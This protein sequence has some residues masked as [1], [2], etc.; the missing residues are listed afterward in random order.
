MCI[1][2]REDGGPAIR[3]IDA[4]RGGELIAVFA[5]KAFA[6]K[7][8]SN[9]DLGSDTDMFHRDAG[10]LPSPGGE[11]HL[12][13]VTRD[14]EADVPGRTGDSVGPLLD[15]HRTPVSKPA[16]YTF[17]VRGREQGFVVSP[18]A[19]ANGLRV[20][21]EPSLHESEAEVLAVAR[22]SPSWMLA[23]GGGAVA[24]DPDYQSMKF[25]AGVALVIS[26]DSSPPFDPEGT[27]LFRIVPSGSSKEIDGTVQ[28]DFETAGPVRPARV[29]PRALTFVAPS[30]TDAEPQRMTLANT[31]SGIVRFRLGNTASWLSAEPRAGVL[32]PYQSAEIGIRTYSVGVVPDTY[33]RAVTVH[34]A[35]EMGTSIGDQVIE[36]AFA[37]VPSVGKSVR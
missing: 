11:G 24:P 37:V 18:P 8:V 5:V 7:A 4:S 2:D 19:G 35:D 12:P 32:Q 27:Y 16:S 3:D 20:R 30:Y 6:A 9:V 14:W 36:V 25:E 23:A 17:Q 15:W 29:W 10:D 31:G 21:F 13:G 1:R 34:L 28:V 26:A 22:S 33:R